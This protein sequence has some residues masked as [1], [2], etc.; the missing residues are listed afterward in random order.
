MIYK[1]NI[2]NHI[3]MDDYKL[4]VTLHPRKLGLKLPMADC[5][6]KAVEYAEL[7]YY[8]VIAIDFVSQP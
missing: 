8:I 5:L 1:K 3:L 4:A 2:I 7:N 6:H